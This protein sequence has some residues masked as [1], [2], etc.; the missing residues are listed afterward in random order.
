LKDDD[1]DEEHVPAF[2]GFRT[3]FPNSASPTA[4]ANVPEKISLVIDGHGTSD[5]VSGGPDV[6]ARTFSQNGSSSRRHQRMASLVKNGLSQ[7]DTDDATRNI[8]DPEKLAV[9][10]ADAPLDLWAMRGRALASS[11][12]STLAHSAVRG[13]SSEVDLTAEQDNDSSNAFTRYGVKMK[14]W[15]K[16]VELASAPWKEVVLSLATAPLA[17]AP[18]AAKALQTASPIPLPP[19][20]TKAHRP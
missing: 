7:D 11:A 14:P 13:H 12:V 5:A 18:S 19:P 15:K 3:N 10:L 16:A 9:G 1:E 8:I 2:A 4:A 17:Q 20:V 6:P